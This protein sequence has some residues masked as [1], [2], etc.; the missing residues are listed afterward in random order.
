MKQ[1]KD[2]KKEVDAMNCSAGTQEIVLSTFTISL[3]AF[4]ENAR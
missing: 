2:K 1:C 3:F 4:G